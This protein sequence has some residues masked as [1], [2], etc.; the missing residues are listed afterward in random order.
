MNGILRRRADLYQPEV[1]R[2]RAKRHKIGKGATHIDAGPVAYGTHLILP[3]GKRF[4]SWLPPP[5]SFGWS[6]YFV[7]HDI[8]NLAFPDVDQAP[9]G[10]LQGAD[11]H[12]QPH[13]SKGVERGWKGTSQLGKHAI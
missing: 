5:E 13:E 4:A 7:H 1:A 12:R 2:F 8:D 9:G 3:P 6:T 10:D 11:L